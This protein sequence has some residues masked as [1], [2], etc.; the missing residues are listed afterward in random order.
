MSLLE[1]IQTILLQ[2]LTLIFE[3]IYMMANGFLDD[4]GLSIIALSLMMNFLV[5]PLYMRADAMQ[6]EEQKMEAKLAPGIAHIKKTFKGDE[7]VM[8]LQTYYRQNQY[9]PT[10]VLRSAMSLLLEIPFFIAAYNFLSGLTLLSGVAFGP[11]QDLSRPDGLLTVAGISVNV[12]PIVMTAVNLVSCMIF[13]KGGAL[14]S[15]IQLYAMALFFLVFLY[16]SPSGLVFYWTLNNVFSLVKT[17]FY[18]LKNPGRILAVLA[19]IAGIGLIVYTVSSCDPDYLRRFVFL[20]TAGLGLQIPALYMAAKEKLHL[21]LK[22]PDVRPEPRLF[23]AGGLFL[24]LLI[25]AVIP[26]E[27]IASSPQEFAQVSDGYS[28]LWYIVSSFCVAFGTFVVWFGVF[29]RLA[30]PAVRALMDQII[31]IGVGA[32]LVNYLCFGRDLG[33]LTVN[34][35]FES[36]LD[37]YMKEQLINAGVLVVAAGALYGL[38]LVLKKHLTRIVTVGCIALCIMSGMNVY[39]IQSDGS[40]AWD[41]GQ[42]Q[43]QTA[44]MPYFTMSKTGK[45][46][47]VIMLDRAVGQYIP[48][49]FQEKPELKEQFAGFT[50]YSNV[51]SYGSCTN[52]ASP[53]LFGGYE[54]T[55]YEMN[56]RD[57]ESLVSKHNEALKVMPVLF[58]ENDFEVTVFD[59]VYANYQWVPDLSIYEEYPDIHAYNTNGFFSDDISQKQIDSRK[60]NFFYYGLMKSMPLV[61]QEVLYDGGSY[62]EID[63]YGTQVMYDEYTADGISSTFMDSYNVLVNMSNMTYLT[64]ESGNHLLMMTNDTTHQHMMLQE[65]DYIPAQHVD[66][67][68]YEQNNQDRFVVDGKRINV[69]SAWNLTHYQANMVSL[70]RLGEWFDY[71]RE[72][73]V[74]D[75]TRIILVADHGAK[76]YNFEELVM[77]NGD[78]IGWYIPLLM[79]KDFGSKEFTVCDDFMTNA[80]VPTLAMEG[81]IQD[82]VNPFT[83]NPI[84]TEAKNAPV[85]YIFGSYENDVSEN[86]GNTFLPD[87]WYSVHD[88]VHDADNWSIVR[89]RG[90]LPVE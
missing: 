19:S 52:F 57:K 86:N 17:I 68:D 76:L 40:Q 87:I 36:G 10:Y 48:Y 49:L 81:L 9:K 54:Y 28:L 21:E 82:P 83:G 51:V 7:Q 89:E 77:E 80:D 42:E 22:L 23:L 5:L 15:K 46:V 56:K 41:P 20:L 4:P 72:N 78:D 47:V 63:F 26:S 70:M 34:L 32:A 69:S 3:F 55:P 12:L 66:N 29:Y 59:P 74:Y 71:L 39:K 88:N 13:T 53:P 27:V 58:D 8:M 24:S 90:T 85:Q 18:K 11:I 45:N 73:G 64:E 62:N 50:Y 67:T 33:I 65:P 84:N 43:T 75:N 37:F 16:D 44:G 79:V 31:W 14:R 38:A 60:R 1:I 6:E 25:G 35:Q 30:K 2:P 61:F